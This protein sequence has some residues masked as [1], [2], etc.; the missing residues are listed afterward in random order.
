[1]NNTPLDIID[2][3]S[4]GKGVAKPKDKVIFVEHTV[5]GDTVE[6]QILQE[7]SNYIQAKATVFH[8][9]SKHRANPICEHFGKCGGCQLQHIQ[10]NYQQNYKQNQV[11]ENL[12]RIAK[13]SFPKI[14]PIITSDKNI[15]Y[16]NKL[17]FT[18]CYN[19]L[20]EK[21]SLGFHSKQSFKDIVD[22]NT[23]HLQSELSNRIQNEIKTFSLAHKLPFFNIQTKKGVLRNLIIRTTTT[24]ELMVIVVFGNRQI[25]KIEI[26]MQH[27]AT[28][29][30]EITSLQ[31]AINS[32]KSDS[33]NSQRII[34]FKGQPTLNEKLGELNLKISAKS[35]YQV[36]SYLALTLCQ[37]VKDFADINNHQVVYDLYTGIGTIANFLASDAKMV[38]GIE[39]IPEAIADAKQNSKINHINN[40]HFV[41]GDLKNTL[42]NALISKHGKPNVVITD[43]PRS[44]MHPQ[45]IQ[46]LLTL[47]PTTII[48]ISC[49]PATQA[50]DIALLKPKYIVDKI[51]PIDMFPH[52]RHVESVVRL[53]IIL[54][55][56]N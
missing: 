48:Y 23:C 26:L 27:L 19:P 43:P 25:Q 20:D 17:E 56:K 55:A 47:L 13:V 9:K 22:I 51:Q 21:S 16:R 31:Y 29:F 34:R 49:N 52:T 42:N 24:Q 11:K 36:N 46:T 38:I 12:T 14:L 15:F 53:K 7:R 39:N 45:V 18:F 37:I 54:D 1:M 32:R 2:L 33:L 10:Y 35:F 41:C 44:G 5:P 40:T 3:T 8:Q 30:P 6:I 4:D 50:R 28:S